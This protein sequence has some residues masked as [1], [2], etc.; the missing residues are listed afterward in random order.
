MG[1]VLPLYSVSVRD[2]VSFVWRSG[3]LGGKG[4]FA[5][6][7]RAVE[8]TRGHQYVQKKRP[9]A[10]E[11]EVSVE[12]VIET[13]ELRLHL[14]GRIDGL[15]A[16]GSRLL[17]E[18]IKTVRA[19]RVPSADLL[20][21]AQAKI[22]AFLYVEQRSFDQIEIQV[23]YLELKSR[24][25]T[26]FKAEFSRF[27]LE[28]FFNQTVE[29]YLR[30][31]REFQEWRAIRDESIR[32]APFPHGAYR[33][34]QRSL[35][36]AVYKTIKN[37][38]RLFAEAPTGIGKT[39]SVLFPAIKALPEGKIEKIFYLTAKTPG[40]LVAQE[41]VRN[42]ASAGLRLRAATITARDKICF[43]TEATCD[44][45]ACPYAKGYYDRVKGAVREA[46]TTEEITRQHI[47]SI[48]R[49]HMVCPYELSLD[50]A[51]W[52]DLVIC[53]YNYVFDPSAKL[54]RF[55]E[56]EPR[57]FAVLV[58]ESHNLIERA[59][60]MFSAE[61]A[62][63]HLEHVRKQVEFQLPDC[64]E[65]LR[66][67]RR[68]LESLP[69]SESFRRRD[70]NAYL[71]AT[72]PK[73]LEKPLERF[74]ETAEQWLGL[75]EPASFQPDLLELY[76]R[77]LAFEQ[78]AGMYGGNYVSI[79]NRGEERLRLFCLDPANFLAE[80]LEGRGSAVFFSATLRPHEF[81][82]EAL[83]GLPTDAALELT[84][85]YDSSR[86]RLLV[87]GNIATNWKQRET[88]LD[89]VAESIGNV[90][91]QK[92]GNY[93]AYFPSYRYL[94]SVLERFAR[95][96]PEI[97]TVVQRTGMNDS[98]RDQFMAR[99]QIQSQTTMLGLAVMGGVFGEG[100]DLVGERL[101]GAII[102]GV[103]LPQLNLERDLIKEYYAANK[104]DGFDFAYTYPGMTK[105][106][107]AA[108]R[109]IRSEKDQGV[110]LLIDERFRR[111]TYQRLFPPWWEP[112]FV[113]S[114]ED[115]QA[116]LQEFWGGSSVES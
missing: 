81:F 13:P 71:S 24:A 80:A 75:N 66:A 110:V 41:S 20:H 7:N 56:E 109:V 37:E 40:R 36:V 107:Q 60:E 62:L 74:L 27:E 11:S 77:I 69:E 90:V 84:S 76:F 89:Q 97:E 63:E 25:L 35:A 43:K 95:L 61:I 102:I 88:T 17:I 48:A 86:L 50:V 19:M 2:L 5:G 55:F 21:I 54:K 116:D 57:K 65:A 58:D 108:G 18:E 79:W 33:P 114:A 91:L 105:V 53:D 45:Q 10:Y 78:V 98:E 68:S 1:S 87:R 93:I 44:V 101:I 39:I 52:V 115:I 70:E 38:G 31:M 49:K 47:E 22:Y 96:F 34:G 6:R 16:D 67:L 8:G 29:E 23:T 14:R 112:R 72:Y 111:A 28:S 94:E 46:L 83:G 73:V 113:A 99:F 9:P 85:P 15:I 3:D 51:N 106:L 82:R 12:K 4:G 92:K 104:K 30:W 42:L 32:A 26:E 59:R 64:S 103:G 100:I